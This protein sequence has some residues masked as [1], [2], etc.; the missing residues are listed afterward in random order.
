MEEIKKII[1]NSIMTSVVILV[2]G[3]IIQSKEVYIG[4]FSGSL[5]SILCFYMIYIDVKTSI[6]K[7]ANFKSGVL[8]YLKRYAIYLLVLAGASYFYDLAMMLGTAIGLLNIK[9]NILMMVLY[10]NLLKWK[11]KYLK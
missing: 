6:V 4:M 8:G 3:I 2:Y 5:I 1:R 10:K 7:G 11:K 9:F